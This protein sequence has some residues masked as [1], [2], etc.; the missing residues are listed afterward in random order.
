[1]TIEEMLENVAPDER[2]KYE[3]EMRKM[4]A[5]E[6]IAVALE[7]LDGTGDRIVTELFN[8]HNNR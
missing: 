8:I 7:E 6:R 5:L 2:L 1:M 3:L 4:K